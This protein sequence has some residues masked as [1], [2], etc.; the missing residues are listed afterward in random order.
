ML[1]I[2]SQGCRGVLI[3]G[4]L[5]AAIVAAAWPG[6]VRSQERTTPSRDVSIEREKLSLSG[7]DPDEPVPAYA[8]YKKGNRAMPVVIFMHGLGGSK[9]GDADRLRDLARKGFFVVAI[10]AYLHGERKVPGIFGPGRKM[11]DL[12]EDYSIWVH[13]SS[14]SHTAR[15]VSKIIDALSARADV[16][17]SRVAVMGI[18]MGSSTCM[19]LTC[20]EPRITVVVGFIGAVDFW[21]DVTKT[22]PGADQDAKRNG[23]SPRVRQLVDSLNPR[24][25]MRAIA[26]KALFL[27][28]GARDGGI[29]IESVRSF[30]KDLRPSYEAHADRLT[31]LE[32]PNAG[33]TV[34][35][36]MWAEGTKWLLRHLVEK[37]VRLPR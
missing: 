1:T 22:P 14:V 12:G 27:A 37:P 10:D 35:D 32:E 11:G 29:D 36:R 19:V 21:Y 15:D 28:N 18:S 23:L 13:Q 17:A 30:V 6:P 25:R 7:W 3:L 34:T 2:I 26:P 9:E 20:K 31:L 5:F 24:D 33:H 8:Y 4:S 16:D